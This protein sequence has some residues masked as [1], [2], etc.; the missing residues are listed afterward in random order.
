MVAVPDP[1]ILLGE[2]APQVRPEGM[3]SVMLTVPVNLFTAVTVTIAAP[4]TPELI[5]AGGVAASVK[6]VI[7]KRAVAE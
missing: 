6:S 5:G 7:M 1:V 3:V 4:D 2:I